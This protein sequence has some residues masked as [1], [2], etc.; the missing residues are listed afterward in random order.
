MIVSYC[1]VRTYAPG[2][3]FDDGSTPLKKTTKKKTAKKPGPLVSK[4]SVSK[5]SVSKSTASKPALGKSSRSDAQKNKSAAKPAAPPPSKI[6]AKPAGSNAKGQPTGANLDGTR[7][8][9]VDR[10]REKAAPVSKSIS[11]DGAVQK[12]SNSKPGLQSAKRPATDVEPE[13]PMKGRKTKI[14]PEEPQVKTFLNDKQLEEFKELLLHKR[15]QLTGD[16]QG[17]ANEARGRS[18]QGD[19]EHS[20]MPIHMADLGS[21]TWEQDFTLGLIANVEGVVRE[22]DDALQ[23]IE[24]RTY[25]ICLAGNDRINVARLRAKPWA[26]HCIEHARLVEEGR[27]R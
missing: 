7:R 18:S 20:N 22:I 3:P 4:A 15:A 13:R 19:S 8:S 21:D 6:V 25:G 16:V 12:S 14:E 10:A 9:T 24:T 11:A 17:L 27:L 1:P 26:K 5:S 2:Q 23:R